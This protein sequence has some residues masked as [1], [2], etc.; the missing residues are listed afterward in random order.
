MI[1]GLDIS[2]SITGTT[3]LNADGKVVLCCAVDMR[4][5]NSFPSLF[6]K[7]KHMKEQ[8][9]RLKE[10]HDIQ[11]IYIEQS[12]QA[13]RPGLS[14]AKVLLTLAKFNGIIS[15]ICKEVFDIEPEYI[16]ASTARKAYGI[17]LERGKNTKKIVLNFVLDKEDHFDVRY[18]SHGNPVPS[19]YD[20]ADSLV[21]A[22]AGHLMCEERNEERLL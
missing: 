6:S 19:T 21:I 22:R 1:L 12:L 5:K 9:V 10:S 2:T 15:W 4:N 7:A 17:K 14:S 16:A 20:R 13:F 3:V 11:K 18:T 8:L